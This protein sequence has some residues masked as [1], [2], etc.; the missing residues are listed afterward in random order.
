VIHG[1]QEGRSAWYRYDA[2]DVPHF[3]YQSKEGLL[4]TNL[5]IRIDGSEAYFGYS[6]E[7][8]NKTTTQ[9]GLTIRTSTGRFSESFSAE[10][11]P[12]ITHA[13]T[14]LIYR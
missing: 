14:C 11:L 6:F 12:E 9:Y 2:T 4:T 1:A 8:Q 13:G 7:N 3:D 10:G 5:F